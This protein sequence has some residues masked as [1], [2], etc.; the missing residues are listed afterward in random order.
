[1]EIARVY[2]DISM[3]MSFKGLTE[4]MRKSKLNPE[5]LA[6]EQFTLFVNKAQTAFKVLIGTHYLVYHNNGRRV[7]P[8]EAVQ[9][10]PLFFDG[11][12]I[13]FAGAARK[14][15]ERKYLTGGHS[16]AYKQKR[17][18]RSNNQSATK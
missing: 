15:I 3:S 2:L 5:S 8:L 13:D 14:V 4:I 9:E 17:A 12:K 6:P 18:T 11:H 7:F 16:E 10:F 1:M